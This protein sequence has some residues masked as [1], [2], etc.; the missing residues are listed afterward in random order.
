VSFTAPT[1]EYLAKGSVMVRGERHYLRGAPVRLALGLLEEN[2]TPFL[3][4]G[5]EA[6]ISRQTGL[7]VR[8]VPGDTKVSDV[9]K[10]LRSHFVSTAPPELKQKIE[11]ISIDE[12]VAVL[13]PGS[14]K[15]EKP[16]GGAFGEP[17]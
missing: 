12:I 10:F 17:R 14:A 1:G 6:A 7:Y 16:D 11:A 13:P 3:V 5:P 2:G 9:A 4:A 15:V 8:L